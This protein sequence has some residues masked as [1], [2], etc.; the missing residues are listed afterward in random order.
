MLAGRRGAQTLGPRL[1]LGLEAPQAQAR[2]DRGPA[3]PWGAAGAALG[4]GQAWAWGVP[5]AFTRGLSP[6]QLM[7][8]YLY[9]G[10]TESMDIPTADIL[11]VRLPG[12]RGATPT[13]P[14]LAVHPM[15][16]SL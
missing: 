15:L 1:V 8:Q 2:G 12:A 16:V 14:R 13:G 5:P 11:E 6:S 9:H 4:A 10:G 3:G 7:M